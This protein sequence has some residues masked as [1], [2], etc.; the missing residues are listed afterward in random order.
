MSKRT[1]S[2][3]LGSLRAGGLTA[4][5]LLVVAGA[6]GATGIVIAREFGR[7][8]ETDGLLAAYGVFIVVVVAAQAI[9]VSVLPQLARAAEAGRL[10]GE[11]AGYAAALLV[12]AVP[13]VVAAEVWADSI[14]G[15]LTGDESAVARESAATALRWMVPAAIMHLFAGLAASGLAALDDYGTAAFGYALGSA[16]GL[17]LILLRAEPDGIV[18]VA[19]GTT[20]NGALA[21]A[22][23]A[24]GLVVRARRTRMPAAAVRPRGL[25]FRARL[26]AF[27]VGAALPISLQLL[28]LVSL[29]F[30]AGLGTGEATT[31][32]YGYLAASSL[33]AVTAGSLGLVTAVPLA[34]GTFTAAEVVR[35][36][37]SSSWFALVLVG[38]AAG[39]FV[40]AGGEVVRAVLG[41]AYGGDVGA[42]LGELVVALSP[43]MVVSIGVSVAFPLAFVAGRTRRLPWIA[44]GALVL[45]APLAWAG[46]E[47]LHLDGLALALGVSTLVVLLALLAE[48][49]A[50]AATARG[51]ALA[52]LVV[53]ALTVAAFVP[54]AFVLGALASAVCG[55]VLY[56]LLVAL[57]R[58]RPLTAS[59]RYLR[60]LR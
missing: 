60:G 5:S 14:G 33:V 44:L 37:V 57:V 27:A 53:G 10:A 13:L 54:P 48:L 28:Y 4:V 11:L 59:W 26:Q 46:V 22:V 8:A 39:A 36:V 15:L 32:V 35:H 31:F 19:W 23:P 58:P 49:G 41:S 50:L 47:L 42:D 52:A 16:A 24:A 9:R 25:P 2:S 17:A 1:D 21:L 7:T 3:G 6:S 12:V 18:A 20:L 55:L 51:L 29:P 38:A 56:A 45:Q 34:R 43:W 40:V 30:A